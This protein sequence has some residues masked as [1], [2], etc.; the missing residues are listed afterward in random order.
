MPNSKFDSK[1]FNPEAFRYMVGHVP[2]LKLNEIKKSRALAANPDIRAVFSNENGT[3]YARIAMRG[4]LDGDAVNYDGS[5]N[6]TASSTK[7]FEQGVVVVGRAKAWVERDFSYDIT[8]GVDFMGNI[9]AQVAEYK[10]GLDQSTILSILKGIFSMAGDTKSAEFVSK[11]TLNITGGVGDAAKVGATTLNTAM[12]K[13][14]GA[15][16]K[17]FAIVFVHSDVATGLENLNL[18]EHLKYTD[19]D[20]VERAL[21]LGTWNG[22]LVVVDDDMPTAP[23]VGTQGVWNIKVSTKASAGDKIEICGTTFTWVANGG[24]IGDTDLEIPSTDNATNQATAIYTKLAAITTGDI[25]KFTWT[26][27]SGTNVTAT[28]KTTAPGAICT[29]EVQAGADMVITFTNPTEPV[30]ATDYTTYVI[31]TGAIS[32]EDL[33]AKVP[34]EMARDPKTNGGEDTLYMRQ[35]KCFAPFGLSYEKAVQSTLSPTDAELQNGANW[36]L[37]HTGEAQAS[38]R[39]Y[40]NHKAIAIARIISR[41]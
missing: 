20:G 10:D 8:G 34:Y 33:G 24:T 19:K 12:N 18:L 25:A 30:E 5:T 26:N 3:G 37:V 41:G 13:A 11:H 7:T 39:T 23:A 40:I 14:C 9:A 35:R 6:I 15:N 36:V 32:Y 16:K 28:Q 29:A 1:S 38:D 21:D 27:P 2:N 31:G 4:L 17:K 22:K